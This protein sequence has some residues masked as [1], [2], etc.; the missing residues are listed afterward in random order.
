[1]SQ[2]SAP[3]LEPRV[4]SQ[5]PGGNVHGLHPRG[6]RA[7]PAP[8]FQLIQGRCR[9]LGFYRDGAVGV[10][11]GVAGEAQLPGLSHGALTVENAL[12]EATNVKSAVLGAYGSGV[13]RGM[14]VPP[15]L[16]PPVSS[17]CQAD[18]APSFLGKGLAR[19]WFRGSC[20]W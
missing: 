18:A 20:S 8:G 2:H 5:R 14:V 3:H 17:E 11:A 13:F 4:P 7:L 9:A 6:R 16:L 12:H 1:M 19:S 15:T 10:I